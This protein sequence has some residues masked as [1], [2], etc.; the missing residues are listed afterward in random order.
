MRVA[1][2][3]LFMGKIAWLNVGLAAVVMQMTG[4]IGA[5]QAVTPQSVPA[6]TPGAL[7][8]PERPGSS[9]LMDEVLVTPSRGQ[10][11]N[12][13]LPYTTGSIGSQEFHDRTYR[14]LPEALKY[15]SGI[16]VQ[17]T[18]HGQGSP[19]IRGFTGYQTLMLI[20]GIRLNNSVFRSGPNQ[21]WNTVDP[22]SIQSMEIV[23][24]PGSVLYGSDAVGGVVN[25]L[26]RGPSD[27]ESGW[28]LGGRLYYRYSS[29]G[30]DSIVRGELDAAVNPDLG[31]FVGGTGKWF[32]DLRGGREVGRQN[33][34]AYNEYDVDF[35]ARYDLQDNVQLVAAHQRVRINNAP[36]THQTIYS[37]TWDNLTQGNELRRDL[38]QERELTYVQLHATEM[39]GPVTEAHFNVSWHQQNE[40]RHRFRTG[41]RLDYQGFD[42]GTLGLFATFASPSPIGKLT[43]GVEYYRDTVSSFNSGN[44]IQG[45]VADDA[46]Y[47]LLGLFVQD[48]F[49]ITD[50][51]HF[52][53]G[54]RFTYARVDANRVRDPNTGLA[55]TITED[56]ASAVGSA[57]LVADV[58]PD[59]LHWYGGVSQAFR[60][61]NLSDVSRFDTARTN[62]YEIPVQGL[63]P[64]Y[65][66][67]FE[68][69]LK[70][71][72]DWWEAQLGY[73]YT[74]IDD[75]IIR[76][77]HR[78]RG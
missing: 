78:G 75:M 36:R 62:E 44:P 53:L 12:M 15:T 46:T 63:D 35:K 47:D 55:M 43:Y 22:L 50:R 2:M 72:Q 24:G 64:E 74:I 6:T 51:L 68:T 77:P 30:N 41:N 9:Y 40:L 66:I 4:M 69:G 13:N 5:V 71:R 16:L 61:P 20:D 59:E 8:L 38:D 1:L 42:V 70:A 73:Y 67:S 56:W 65:Y 14:T 31:L 27:T 76:F 49:D 60:A 34:T 58:V 32:G 52:T 7:T 39:D 25:V 3:E 45:P 10:M 23:K 54:G 11:A 21:Y 57:R 48:E 17:Q 26:T 29:A 37:I 33:N 18:G 28:D 19:Y